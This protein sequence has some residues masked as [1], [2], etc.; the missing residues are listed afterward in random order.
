MQ[1]R[2]HAAQLGQL[3]AEFQ[4]HNFEILLILGASLDKAK[5]Y[6]EILHLPFPVLADPER[7]VYHQYGL[8][9]SMIFIQ[10]TASLIIDPKGRIRYLRTTT[11]PMVWL[12]ESRELL[13]IVQQVAVVQD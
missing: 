5:H 8:Q 4:A 3:Y 11:S 7:K 10:R 1:C 9:M 12:Q 2:S 13:S 6:A